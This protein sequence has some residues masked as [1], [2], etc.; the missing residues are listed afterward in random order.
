MAKKIFLEHR[1]IMG[2]MGEIIYAISQIVFEIF[3]HIC[4]PNIFE[5]HNK[6]DIKIVVLYCKFLIAFFI[7]SQSYF[8]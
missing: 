8:I 5:R 6:L 2:I 1:R 3:D 7:Q 4:D